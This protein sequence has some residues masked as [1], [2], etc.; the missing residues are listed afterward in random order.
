MNTTVPDLR[1]RWRA[2]GSGVRAWKVELVAADA[3]P[4]VTVA[5]LPPG[6]SKGYIRCSI[7][8]VNLRDVT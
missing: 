7:L 4:K 1:R 2:N 8:P 6:N 3:G 5:H